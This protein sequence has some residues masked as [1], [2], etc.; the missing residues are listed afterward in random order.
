MRYE[1]R[2]SWMNP[3]DPPVSAEGDSPS[4]AKYQAY[5]EADWCNDFEDFL[6]SVVSC[7]KV[8]RHK[9]CLDAAPPFRPGDRVMMTDCPEAD[10]H[11]GQ[12]WTVKAGPQCLCGSWVVWLTDYPGAFDCQ[13][14]KLTQ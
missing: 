4:K 7:K 8:S 11:K 1:L 6:K 9:G 13:R 3:T 10:S 2:F 14:L 12:I 5:L